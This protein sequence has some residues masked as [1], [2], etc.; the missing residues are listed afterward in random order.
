MSSKKKPYTPQT[1]KVVPVEPVV[2]ET[3]QPVVEVEITKLVLWQDGDTWQSIARKNL[4][5]GWTRND[6]AQ[7]LFELNGSRQLR[8]GSMVT[9]V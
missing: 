1:T 5:E 7:A 2:E 4:P 9:L 6:Y 3:F 8:P